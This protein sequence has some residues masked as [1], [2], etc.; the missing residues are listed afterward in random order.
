M[1]KNTPKKKRVSKCHKAEIINWFGN[2]TS[3]MLGAKLKKPTIIC[4]KCSQPCEVI[5]IE[6]INAK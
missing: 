6:V 2:V 3:V 4:M 5:E 1:P